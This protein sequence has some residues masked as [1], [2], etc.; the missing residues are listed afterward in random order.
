MQRGFR[1]LV[2][3]FSRSVTMDTGALDVHNGALALLKLSLSG[4]NASRGTKRSLA[5]T[6]AEVHLQ[7]PPR[8]KLPVRSPARRLEAF[9][10][11][12]ASLWPLPADSA[13]LN[14]TPPVATG[15]SLPA[16]Q[17]MTHRLLHRQHQPS[18]SGADVGTTADTGGFGAASQFTTFTVPSIMMMASKPPPQH[19]PARLPPPQQQ[20]QP[21][22]PQPPQPQPPQPPQPQQQQPQPQPQEQQPQ[23]QPPGERRVCPPNSLHGGAHPLGSG[24][25]RCLLAAAGADSGYSGGGV[26]GGDMCMSGGRAPYRWAGRVQHGKL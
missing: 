9:T 11:N 6:A 20:Q 16:A 22:P 17:A 21:P 10:A 24:Q 1:I 14:P 3:I 25:A 8:S 12:I 7:Q 19:L 5:A 13:G 15:S 18:F 23:P 26:R 2:T 4:G